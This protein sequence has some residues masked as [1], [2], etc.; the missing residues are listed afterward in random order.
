MLPTLRYR[1]EAEHTLI[2]ETKKSIVPAVFGAMVIGLW[3]WAILVEFAQPSLFIASSVSPMVGFIALMYYTHYDKITITSEFIRYKGHRLWGARTAT[4]ARR[5]LCCVRVKEYV[6][7]SDSRFAF[8][9]VELLFSDK[10][11]PR[12][13]KVFEA[14]SLSRAQSVAE[15]LCRT[16]SIHLKFDG[17]DGGVEV[18]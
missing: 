11:L 15:E 1:T 12:M 4:A 8:F 3:S 18:K 14:R 5:A 17:K 9:N 10:D 7:E 13:M 6:I 2:A 16:L